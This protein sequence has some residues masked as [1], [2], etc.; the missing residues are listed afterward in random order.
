MHKHFYL[1][2]NRYSF[3]SRIISQTHLNTISP[4]PS[5]T[6]SLTHIQCE[7][8]GLFLKGVGDKKIPTQV[9]QLFGGFLAAIFKHV[10][11]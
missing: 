3:G 6:H 11:F 7:E 5:M 2:V 4:Q 9:A 10:T 1:I 8:I